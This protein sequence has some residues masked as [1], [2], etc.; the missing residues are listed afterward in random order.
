MIAPLKK[1]SISLRIAVTDR[2]QL[3]CLYCMPKEGASLHRH[4]DV[5]SY[6]EIITFVNNLQYNYNLTKVRITGGEPLARRNIESLIQMLHEINIPDIGIT[7]NGQLLSDKAQPLKDAGLKR[8]NVSLDSLSASTFTKL[9]RGGTLAHTLNGIEQAAS[10][11]LNPIKLNTVVMKGINDNEVTSILNY[12]LNNNLQLRFL[13]L[14]PLETLPH[15]FKSLFTPT[16]EIIETLTEQFELSPITKEI[17]SNCASYRVK[18][19]N[20]KSGTVGFI[21]PYSQPFCNGCRRLRLSSDGY[22]SGC[23]ALN[24]RTYIRDILQ[25]SPTSSNHLKS[26]IEN[27]MTLKR[28]SKKFTIPENMVSIGG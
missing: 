16:S 14:M 9:T 19:K 28:T 27:A 1:S 18:S 7:T 23:L 21:S 26:C 8:V 25:P 10:A 3:R 13:E 24:N 15:D 11:G 20:G 2:C 17:N 6:E 5:L 12:A 22:I 4:Q